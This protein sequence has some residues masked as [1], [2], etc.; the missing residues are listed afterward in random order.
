MGL[1]VMVGCRSGRSLWY[2][3]LNVKSK[4][5][6]LSL[7]I[8]KPV[9]L[10]GKLFYSNYLGVLNDHFVVLKMAVDIPL[11]EIILILTQIRV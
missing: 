3:S 4:V 11:T 1:V 6:N 8:K 10:Q 5:F 2:Q 7:N 9:L